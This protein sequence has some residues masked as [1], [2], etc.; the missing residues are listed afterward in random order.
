MAC[1]DIKKA[2]NMVPQS[3]ILPFFIMYKIP[4][5]VE[6]FIEKTMET[7]RVELT[8]AGKSLAEVKIQRAIFQG[9]AQSSI[10]FVIAM[11]PLNHILRKCTAGYK[12]SKL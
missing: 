8:I 10:L 1:I 6:Q 9:D 12:F 7:W 5:Q 4:D 3:W 2:Y 11:M